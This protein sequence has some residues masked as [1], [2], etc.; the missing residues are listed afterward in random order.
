M[1]KN[2]EVLIKGDVISAEIKKLGAELSEK[3]KDENPVVIGII[4]GAIY[5]LTELTQNMPI[6]LEIDLMGVSSY[7]NNS[8]TSG[9]VK[10][11]KDV[12]VDITNRTVIIIEDII[13]TGKTLEFLRDY[14]LTKEAKSVETIS[15]FLKEKSKNNT[16][17]P[18]RVLFNVSNDFLVGYGLDYAN[19]YRHLR[20]LC[21]LDESEINT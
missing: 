2:L 12:G 7:G 8:K 6:E 18:D 4:K 21:K 9:H 11:T 17:L 14:F 15:L 19:K 13:D 5:F 3:Y 20:D 16:V 1:N 10:I